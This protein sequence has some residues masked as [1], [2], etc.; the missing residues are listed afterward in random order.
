ML[1]T[2][3]SPAQMNTPL[4][5]LPYEPKL[6][7]KLCTSGESKENGDPERLKETNSSIPPSRFVLLPFL[8]ITQ[9]HAQCAIQMEATIR[10][11]LHPPL[12]VIPIPSPTVYK[13][14]TST[15]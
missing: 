11:A 3:T 14:E 6:V 4:A 10:G 5:A 1:F 12:H 13:A 2:C 9:P 15:S 7:P 8:A